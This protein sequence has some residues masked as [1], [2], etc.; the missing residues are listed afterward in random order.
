MS[1]LVV[2]AEIKNR[3]LILP[4]NRENT[5]LTTIEP[6]RNILVLS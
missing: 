1:G 6:L 5:D 3:C 2:V 4:E